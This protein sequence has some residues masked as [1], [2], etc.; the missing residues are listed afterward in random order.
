MGTKQILTLAT[1]ALVGLMLY[2][3]IYDQ[4]APLM[5]LASTSLDYTYLRVALIA[6]LIAL[7]LSSP[8]RSNKFRLFLAGFSVSLIGLSI[9][10]I[11]TYAAG[12]LDAVVFIEI[13]IL[14]MI[15]ALES[16][17]A[18]LRTGT[19]REVALK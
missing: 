12:I 1:T 13:A 9:W 3:G 18:A 14:F 2:Y 7:L 5:W 19:K 10:L 15:E 16:Q 4:S 11:D 17:P 8:P 6:V